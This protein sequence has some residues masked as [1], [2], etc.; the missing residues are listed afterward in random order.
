MLPYLSDLKNVIVFKIALQISRFTL[1]YFLANSRSHS[2]YAVA[3][4][5]VVCRLSAT[6]VH[7]T[8]PVEIFS[9]V[10]SP[11]GTLATR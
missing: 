2:L 5:F 6:L 11:F 10:S 7:P 8:Q 4:P 3:R 1:L 9:N